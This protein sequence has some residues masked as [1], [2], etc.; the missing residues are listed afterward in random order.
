MLTA[1]IRQLV[2]LMGILRLKT[3]MYRQTLTIMQVDSIKSNL[4]VKILVRMSA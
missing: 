2:I 4:M 1:M 3:L